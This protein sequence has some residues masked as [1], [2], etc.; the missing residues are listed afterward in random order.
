MSTA[1]ATSKPVRQATSS[2]YKTDDTYSR[3]FY[4]RFF[5]S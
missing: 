3:I 4:S 1:S 2:V 5:Y